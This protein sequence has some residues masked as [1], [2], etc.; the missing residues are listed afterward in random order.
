MGKPWEK[1]QENYKTMGKAQE[2]GGLMGF[3]MGI[4]PLIMT[5]IATEICHRHNIYSAF[6]HQKMV[7]GSAKTYGGYSPGWWY[8]YHSEK[9]E[10][11]S[12]DDDIPN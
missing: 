6:Y 9:Y 2:N 12:W 5:H 7:M 10:F 1:P 8:T 3:G 11:V 4:Q